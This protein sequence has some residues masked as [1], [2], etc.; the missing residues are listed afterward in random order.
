MDAGKCEEI[1]P[2][3]CQILA[4]FLLSRTFLPFKGKN[5]YLF[6]HVHF[7]ICNKVPNRVC[8]IQAKNVD[9]CN[10][11]LKEFK[12]SENFEHLGKCVEKKIQEAGGK[13]CK[14]GAFKSSIFPY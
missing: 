12:I 14:A 2:Q 5:V 8:C 13:K 9:I 7:H 3:M 4:N 11:L 10:L 6:V 1:I